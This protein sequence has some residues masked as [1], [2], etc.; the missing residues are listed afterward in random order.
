MILNNVAR[1]STLLQKNAGAT[2]TLA[3]TMRMN[4]SNELSFTDALN[5]LQSVQRKYFAHSALSTMDM[6]NSYESQYKKS[7][8]NGYTFM[9]FTF[10]PYGVK[11]DETVPV[12]FTTHSNGYN[13]MPLYLTVMALD[14]SGNLNFNY[15]Y[16][17]S[18]TTP[19]KIEAFH[20]YMLKFFDTAINNPSMTLNQLMDI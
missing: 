3:I 1:R 9:N 20:A 5:E 12:H 8:F 15:D 16:N 10:Q 14:N 18:F 19:E 6:I 2:F 4:F 17:T 7:P 13:A 11:M